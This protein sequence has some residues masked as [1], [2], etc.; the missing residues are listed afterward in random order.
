MSNSKSKE[1]MLRQSYISV[2]ASANLTMYE[3]RLILMCVQFGQKRLQGV[4]L[5]M[6]HDVLEHSFNLVELPVNIADVVSEGTEHYNHVIKAAES[7]TKR[8][9]TYTDV[10]GDKVATLWVLRVTH[11][12]RSGQLIL[13]L[14]KSF[15]DTLYNFRKGFCYYDLVRAM[16]LKHPQSVKLYQLIN[17][18]KPQGLE[19]SVE[20]LKRAF[21]V[22]DKYKRNNDFV[23]KYIDVACKELEAQQEGNYFRYKVKK[24]NNKITKICIYPVKRA[25]SLEVQASAGGVRKWLQQ[26]YFAILIQHAGFTTRQ[27]NSNKRTFERLQQNPLGMSILLDIIQRCRKVRPSNP[28]G[29]VVNAVKGALQDG[30]VIKK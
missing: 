3:Q 2:I 1:E 23:R 10:H 5:S 22:E 17:G 9:F 24:E 8:K 6:H 16:Q 25:T 4:T 7:L 14:D 19:Y 13:L 29:Y 18:L 12:S 21:G 30:P 26:D 20:S 15:F 27:I 11:V 28:Q